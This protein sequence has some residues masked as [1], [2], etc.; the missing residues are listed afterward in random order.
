MNMTG[1]ANTREESQDSMAEISKIISTPID[2][3]DAHSDV[4]MAQQEQETNEHEITITAIL[5]EINKSSSTK[6]NNSIREDHPNE[7]GLKNTQGSEVESK[8]NVAVYEQST[9][10]ES[11]D[12]LL[13]EINTEP[14]SDTP[15]N[16]QGEVTTMGAALQNINSSKPLIPSEEFT[17]I[18]DQDSLEEIVIYDMVVEYQALYSMMR[19]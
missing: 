9:R 6:S 4:Y 5:E 1:D 10:D 8:S 12:S 17:L 3:N 11:Q 7:T 16:Q 14:P 19:T 15:T 13:G 18:E 2:I